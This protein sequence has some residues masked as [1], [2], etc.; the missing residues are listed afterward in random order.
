[1]KPNNSDI[2]QVDHRN[3][4]KVLILILTVSVLL[5]IGSAVYLGQEVIS[6]PGTFD[7]ISYHN[8]ALRVLGGYGF[9]FGE[10]WWPITDAGEPTAH[11]SYLYTFY[12]AFV[13]KVFG[14]NP[15]IARLI[16][17]FL[18]GILHP[19]FISL[20]GKECLE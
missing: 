1:M 4:I 16:Q 6:L 9:T 12:L 10:K 15:M 17:A 8:L 18:V 7:Q 14:P 19:L 13:Y 2:Q 5:R 3:Q 20:S 11:W